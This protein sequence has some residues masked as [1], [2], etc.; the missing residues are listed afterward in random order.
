M[1]LAVNLTVIFFAKGEMK[2]ASEFPN[3]V[4]HHP[5]PLNYSINIKF[6]FETTEEKQQKLRI[7]IYVSISLEIR[8]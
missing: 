2:T 8:S 3:M 6:K 1:N 4:K 5:V 7:Q